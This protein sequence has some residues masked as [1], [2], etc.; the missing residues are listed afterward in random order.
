MLEEVLR[1]IWTSWRKGKEGEFGWYC[2]CVKGEVSVRKG[3]LWGM[4]SC[5]SYSLRIEGFLVILDGYFSR[6]GRVS[7]WIVEPAYKDMFHITYLTR[8]IRTCTYQLVYL[9]K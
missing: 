7:K 2:E 5:C 4:I 6:F 1:K 9:R 3:S 8:L